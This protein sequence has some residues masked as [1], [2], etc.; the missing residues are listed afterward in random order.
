MAKPV[1]PFSI[2]NN[3]KILV[4]PMSDQLRAVDGLRALSILIVLS[5]HCV[6]FLSIFDP[7]AVE[8]F[9]QAPV[10]LH[11]VFNGDL[12]LDI[13]FVISGFLIS[14]ILMKEYRNS[15][16]IRFG[17]FYQRRFMRLMPAYLLALGLGFLAAP[18]REYIWSNLLYINNL[19]PASTHFMPWTWSLAIEEQFYFLFP[20]LLLWG[21]RCFSAKTLFWSML[22]GFLG[23]VLIRFLVIWHFELFLPICWYEKSCDG[24]FQ[25]IDYIYVKPWTRFGSFLPGIFAAYFH[26]YHQE[27]LVAFYQRHRVGIA[28]VTFLALLVVAVIFTIPVNNQHAT[29]PRLLG[30]IYYASCRHLFTLAICIIMISSLYGDYG[31]CRWSSKFLSSRLL[32]P[33]AQLAYSTYLFHPFVIA[34]VYTGIFQFAPDLPVLQKI[35]IATVGGVSISLLVAFVVFLFIERPFM[36]MRGRPTA[37]PKSAVLVEG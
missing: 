22:L 29:F 26:V 25:V 4:N 1:T 17:R 31:I 36:N 14:T 27:S 7:S 2:S 15:G 32:Y 10:W 12:S 18:N 35:A 28:W 19:L 37:E 8:L 11:W 16:T 5:I 21:M 6:W 9:Y 23:F 13:F 3:L 30:S 20:V 33:I 34:G 24:F